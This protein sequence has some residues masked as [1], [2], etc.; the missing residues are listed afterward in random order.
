MNCAQARPSLIDHLHGE[1]SSSEHAELA[2][3]LGGCAE[4]A[5]QYCRLEAEVRGIGRVFSER[6]SS[7]MAGALR[8]AVEREFSPRFPA[9]ILALLRR[10]VPAYGVLF[11][12]MVPLLVWAVATGLFDPSSG[13]EPSRS[14]PTA[15]PA[16]IRNYDAS[17]PMFDPSLS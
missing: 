4:C 5:V 17:A 8:E 6:P 9:R 2:E 7:A 3:H 1:L 11:A 10:P 12:A 16:R 15:A 14:R 13:A